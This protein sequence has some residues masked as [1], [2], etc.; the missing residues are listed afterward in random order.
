MSDCLDSY[1]HYG[2]EYEDDQALQES[3]LEEGTINECNENIE[4]SD[5]LRRRN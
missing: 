2:N 1:W 4:K 5:R 3:Y